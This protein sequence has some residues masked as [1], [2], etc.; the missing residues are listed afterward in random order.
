MKKISKYITRTVL[1]LSL[2]SLIMSVPVLAASKKSLERQLDSAENVLTRAQDSLTQKTEKY[3]EAKSEYDK[4]SLDYSGIDTELARLLQE[5]ESTA[6]KVESLKAELAAQKQISRAASLAYTKKK[7]S[8]STLTAKVNLKK[9]LMDNA[10]RAMSKA[11]DAFNTAKARRDDIAA[12]LAKFIQD[13]EKQNENKTF[14]LSVDTDGATSYSGET[15]YTMKYGQKVTLPS[16]VK[17]GFDFKG[18]RWSNAYGIDSTY[19]FNQ[20]GTA[21]ALWEKSPETPSASVNR[22]PVEYYD[23]TSWQNGTAQLLYSH[24]FNKSQ[25]LSAAEIGPTLIDVTP[26][27]LLSWNF[28]D[29]SGNIITKE[30][31]YN[32]Y[33]N[34]SYLSN[35]SL[36]VS[37][38]STVRP[39]QIMVT[40]KTAPTKEY[41]YIYGNYAGEVNINYM[42][43]YKK[44]EIIANQTATARFDGT[45]E[46]RT[47]SAEPVVS[48]G[49]SMKWFFVDI[50][51]NPLAKKDVWKYYGSLDMNKYKLPTI[52][53]WGTST[54][55][56][57]NIDL[58][59]TPT[60]KVYVITYT[61]SSLA[62]VTYDPDKPSPTGGSEKIVYMLNDEVF[63]IESFGVAVGEGGRALRDLPSGISYLNEKNG[64]VAITKAEAETVYLTTL[65]INGAVTTVYLTD[66]YSV[67]DEHIPTTLADE[68]PGAGTEFVKGE[69]I[70]NSFT[71]ID[72]INDVAKKLNLTVKS[73][74]AQSNSRYSATFDTNGQATADVVAEANKIGYTLSR[75]VIGS[76]I[77]S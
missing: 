49:N 61:D 35:G 30:Q 77:G 3:N 18:W 63:F 53:S 27:G 75:N 29:T 40:K 31:A 66:K 46:N 25:D 38:S 11:Q 5:K 74:N 44:D 16:P 51:G 37:V 52:T 62:P 55:H 7:I 34:N 71:T 67:E 17:E 26:D 60:M 36:L 8:V 12:S 42:N 68:E 54:L 13:E 41:E 20:N 59:E 9:R 73:V 57:E 24:D 58:G 32:L 28:V 69:V 19:T 6:A 33:W 4:A 14:T 15:S 56:G 43:Y 70:G 72:E 65:S 76:Y 21:K 64:N 45:G 50:N 10:E 22:I 2:L 47:W 1:L 48:S 39:V 23:Y